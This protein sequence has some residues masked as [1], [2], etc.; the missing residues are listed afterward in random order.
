[1]ES[2]MSSGN[3]VNGVMVEGGGARSSSSSVRAGDLVLRVLALVLTLTAAILM[4]VD[5]QTKVVPVVV[6]PNLPPLNVPVTA[7]SHYLSAF[8]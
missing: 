6:S 3:K 5:K 2:Q 7:K 4:G 8:V 1:M